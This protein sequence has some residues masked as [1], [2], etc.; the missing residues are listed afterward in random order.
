MTCEGIRKQADELCFHLKFSPTTVNAL[1][2]S[3]ILQLWKLKHRNEGSYTLLEVKD[4]VIDEKILE[5]LVKFMSGEKRT[6]DDVKAFLT[7]KGLKLCPICMKWTKKL[8]EQEVALETIWTN[9]YSKSKQPVKKEKVCGWCSDFIDQQKPYIPEEDGDL[10]YDMDSMKR[11]DE[12]D[13]YEEDDD[14]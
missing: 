4:L 12:P 9:F 5:E 13:F 14:C 3:M 6:L 2:D 1:I 8:H 11:M 10:L 7:N